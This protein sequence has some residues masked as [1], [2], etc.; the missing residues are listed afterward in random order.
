MS[1]ACGELRVSGN[2]VRGWGQF[3]RVGD[4]W[5]IW[6]EAE[7][8]SGWRKGQGMVLGNSRGASTGP[9]PSQLV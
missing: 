9:M 1:E 3:H 7:D 2:F 4:T 5:W 6:M 8:V